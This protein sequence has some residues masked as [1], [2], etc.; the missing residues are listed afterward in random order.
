MAETDSC[1]SV[2]CRVSMTSPAALRSVDLFRNSRARYCFHWS[3]V[4]HVLQW[5]VL[6]KTRNQEKPTA[7]LGDSEILS[8]KHSRV[9]H[10]TAVG[11]GRDDCLQVFAIVGMEQGR[12]VFKDHPRGLNFLEN[13]YDLKKEPRPRAGQTRGARLASAAGRGDVLAGEPRRD[14]V[15]AGQVRRPAFSHVA[16]P[17]GAGKSFSKHKPVDRVDLNLPPRLPP[18]PLKAEVKPADARK[19][20]TE[21]LSCLFVS[22]LLTGRRDFRFTHT[23]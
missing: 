2:L 16:E 8:I 4:S 18:R 22:R 10:I 23:T 17:L 20:R 14:A 1:R 12:H 5:G 13:T 11:K 7:F 19:E 9:S 3:G 21:G 15:D 6:S